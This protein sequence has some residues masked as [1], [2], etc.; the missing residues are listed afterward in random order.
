M[1]LGQRPVGSGASRMAD[2]AAAEVQWVK[3]LA[4]DRKLSNAA[5]DK[6]AR[7]LC[8]EAT[9]AERTAAL[10]GGPAAAQ[11][12][13][14]A[15]DLSAPWLGQ[16][17][18]VVAAAASPREEHLAF[19]ATV[20]AATAGD[21][22]AGSSTWLAARYGTPHDGAIV[23][24]GG[25]SGPV[26]TLAV[27]WGATVYV[28]AAERA[29]LPWPAWVDYCV[30]PLI[31][32]GVDA[33]QPGGGEAPLPAGLPARVAV[34][35]VAWAAA[36]A[37]LEVLGFVKR[38]SAVAGA[39]GDSPP[40]ARVVFCGHSLGG[41]VALLLAISYALRGGGSS[42]VVP[43]QVVT[44]G[45][46]SFGNAALGALVRAATRHHRWYVDHDAVAGIPRASVTAL[47]FSATA[48]A[49]TAPAAATHW[50]LSA[51]GDRGSGGAVP[52][53]AAAPRVASLAVAGLA[54]GSHHP[55]SAYALCLR[56][57]LAAVAAGGGGEEVRPRSP[58]ARGAAGA[59]A[60]ATFAAGTPPSVA[61]QPHDAAQLLLGS[62]STST[63]SS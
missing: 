38:A 4:A 23:G 44:F 21:T 17:A 61:H 40:A 28:A 51:G 45:C 13:P 1:D 37:Q 18:A 11:A 5:R 24:D 54:A 60:A 3:T 52:G 2:L 33:F 25:G 20:A 47:R 57:H 14:A 7:N 12:S 41:A 36:Q 8:V 48:A 34:N 50:E 16:G 19:A 10:P 27:R 53:V 49:A 55:L 39:D 9:N 63:A 30:A 32:V 6:K 31:K 26:A 56:R 15:G 29:P 43:A 62:V 42:A 59:A 22:A 46:P 35:S 58:D